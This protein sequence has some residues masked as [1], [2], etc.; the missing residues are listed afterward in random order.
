M[1]SSLD[2]TL[3]PGARVAVR[4]CL[5][6]TATDRVFV[7]SDDATL[8]IG[9]ALAHEA[10]ATGAEVVLRRLEEFAARP[11]LDLPPELVAAY[12]RFAPTASFYAAGAQEGEIG[13]RLKL[14]RSIREGMRPRHGHMPG[15]TPLLMREGMVTDYDQVFRVTMRV[16]E[17]ACQART[18]HITSPKG[19]DLQVAF[20]PN[21][22]WI[23]CHGRY[24]QPGDWGNLPEGETYTSPAG[25]EGVL[26]VDVLGDY[27]SEK[28]GLLARPVTFRIAEGLV[29]NVQCDDQSLAAEVWAYLSSAEN[30]RRAG[31]FAIG[32][33]AGLTRL[34]GN[35]LQDEKYPGMHIAFGNPYPDRTGANWSSTI[36]VDVIPTTCTI[37][38]D[39]HRLMT[40]GVFEPDILADL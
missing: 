6:V 4:T 37:E 31:E 33:N 38:V 2:P 11:I 15:I 7:L 25:V 16:Y 20:S 22:H 28:Y 26:V 9:E 5:D 21:L 10:A 12:R 19:T 40:D 24:H 39:G 29:T 13:F 14:G 36:H 27:F 23:P 18:M 34:V 30:G 8:P 35:L 17:I 1:P 32:T 3:L